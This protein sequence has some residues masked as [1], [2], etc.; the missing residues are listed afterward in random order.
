MKRLT[1]PPF[2][3]F[4]MEILTNRERSGIS[5]RSDGQTIKIQE[6]TLPMAML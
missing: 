5:I 1:I 6:M 4:M 3:M 2:L